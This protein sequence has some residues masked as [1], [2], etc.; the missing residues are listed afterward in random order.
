MY[1]ISNKQMED[2]IRYVEAYCLSVGASESDTRK[3]N[4][5]RLAGIL[6]RKLRAKQPLAQPSDIE[7]LKGY[8]ATKK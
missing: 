1:I 4:S 5:V 6:L 3:L 7:P 2:I 8:N